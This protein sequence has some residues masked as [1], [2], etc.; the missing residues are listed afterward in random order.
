VNK[1]TNTLRE[2][3]DQPKVWAECLSML[4]ALDLQL[5][6]GQCN[7]QTHEWIFVGCGTSY[8]LAQAAAH[9][10]TELTG[11]AARAVP[12]SEM[13]LASNLV[14]P[15]EQGPCFPVLIS[16]SGRTSEVLRAG[17]LLRSRGVEFLGV[18]CDGN[19][20]L[21]LTPRVI[22]L[23]VVE[24]STVMT[25]S[26]TSML[27]ALQYLAG[28]LAGNE[29][30]I[31]RLHVLPGATAALLEIYGA[32]VEQFAR[33]PFDDAVILAQGALYPIAQEISLKVMES[34][35]TYAQFFHTLEFRHGPKSI[36]S[37]KT[38]IGA[39]L[40]EAGSEKES[41]V[42][43]EMK[44]LGARTLAIGNRISRDLRSRCD[45]AIEL[46]LPVPELARLVVYAV[47]GQ[48]LGAYS[49]IHKGLDPDSPRNLT[50]VVTLVGEEE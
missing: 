7:P 17:E 12:A 29:A 36:V 44:D 6:V 47:W 41:A 28:R 10:F 34:S 8:Y 13:L 16:R 50:R 20:L 49:G 11:R 42:L 31:D 40:S 25:S 33:H 3:S 9:T 45:M 32:E 2:I 26:F 27:M 24:R 46:D 22:K 38:L 39:L 18:T 21:D 19:D 35:S 4:K 15:R 37:E 48:L 5:L 14:F 23:P 1:G 43:L 30:W